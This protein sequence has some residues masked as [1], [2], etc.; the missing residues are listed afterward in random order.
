MTTLYKPYIIQVSNKGGRQTIEE[1][2]W[3]VYKHT[4]PNGKV[5]IGITS[6]LPEKRWLSGH[7]YKGTYFGNAIKKY[8]WKN[9]KHEILFTELDELDAK[10][11]EVELIEKFRSFEK[12]YGYNLTKGGDGT[13]GLKRSKEQIQLLKDLLSKKVYQRELD[14]TF[15]KEWNSIREVERITGFHRQC[16]TTC[17]HKK[18]FQAYGYL[19]SFDKDYIAKK[20]KRKNC[21]TVYQYDLDGNFIKEWESLI[22][23]E[24]KLGYS[25]NNLS[26]C[27]LGKTPSAYGYIWSYEKRNDIVYENKN[28][29]KQR[30]IYQFSKEMIL[31]EEWDN[32]ESIESTLGYGRSAIATCCRCESKTAY[33][34]IWRYEENLNKKVSLVSAQAKSVLQL[35]KKYNLIKRFDS[36]SE[37]QRIT[38]VDNISSCCNGKR[39]TSGGYIWVYEEDYGNFDKDKHMKECTHIREVNKYD[40]NMNYLETFKSVTEAA[41]DVNGSTGNISLCC[42]GKHKTAYGYIWRYVN[43]VEKSAS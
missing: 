39:K 6:Q 3:T 12:D 43:D 24:E 35:D 19:W 4:T 34:Y 23:I 40:L 28:L 15:I 32:L 38:G 2:K 31:I 11:K 20:K 14:G 17:C 42:S 18:V 21:K 37:A 29:Q 26:H 33:G 8:G 41:R 7:G 9:I 30:K 1:R 16:I 27:C 36:V 25:K 10:E 13:V 5:Y 22:Q